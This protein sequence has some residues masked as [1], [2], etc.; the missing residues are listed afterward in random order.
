MHSSAVVWRTLA[1][2]WLVLCFASVAVAFLKRVRPHRDDHDL[3]LRV[4]GW[5]GILAVATTA[6]LLGR[7]AMV[8]FLAF[9]SFQALKEFFS[10]VLT[11][12]ADRGIVLCAYAVI[13]VQFYFAGTM[14]FHMFTMFVPAVVPAL[15]LS[16]M[17][18]SGVTHGFLTAA[19]KIQWGLLMCV[20][21]V[22]HLAFLYMLPAQPGNVA[23]GRGLLLFLVVSAESN[24]IAQYT[25][26]GVAGRHP[27]LPSI[28]PKK[29]W[30]GLAGGIVITVIVAV[31]LAPSL[32]PFTRTASLCA[33]VLI[34]MLGFLGDAAI[35]AV[36]RDAG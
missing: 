1:G 18:F 8:C 9:V 24:D 25:T 7:T 13:G 3:A 20:Y 30:E 2:L 19:A 23:G 16:G 26:G 17:I 6:L 21:A 10:N 27:I 4:K 32:T 35:S 34:S 11:R 29:T 33:G 12:R 14:R 5:W 22:S 31:L 28:S 15:L 36:K